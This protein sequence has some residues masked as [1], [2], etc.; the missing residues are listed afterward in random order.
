MVFQLKEEYAAT[1][2]MHTQLPEWRDRSVVV[3]RWTPDDLNMSRRC[4]LVRETQN[5]YLEPE[6]EEVLVV[7]SL[8][9]KRTVVAMT[10]ARNRVLSV[11]RVQV[12]SR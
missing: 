9:V 6:L 11:S 1:D 4:V 2:L 5:P 3:P 12:A 7:C 10:H 8:E